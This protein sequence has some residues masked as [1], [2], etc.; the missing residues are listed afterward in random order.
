MLFKAHRVRELKDTYNVAAP[1]LRT[2]TQDRDSMRVREIRAGEEVESMYDVVNHPGT[3]HSMVSRERK[4]IPGVPTE[5]KLQEIGRGL[6]Y[7]ATDAL[8]D[9][10][11]F[12]EEAAEGGGIEIKTELNLLDR[13]RAQ[14]PDLNRFIHDLDSDEDVPEECI[15]HHPDHTCGHEGSDDKKDSD[16][17]EEEDDEEEEDD[18]D[19]DW[20]R[21]EGDFESILDLQKEITKL[22]DEEKMALGFH[23][24]PSEPRDPNE[25]MEGQYLRFLKRESSKGINLWQSTKP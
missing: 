20:E 9:E 4:P 11:L 19:D 2:I 18:D 17:Q 1:I 24:Q 23:A 13:L 7:G 10:I 25:D 14:G 12:P 16:G 8:E 15:D 3:T 21:D 22:N 5:A 6:L